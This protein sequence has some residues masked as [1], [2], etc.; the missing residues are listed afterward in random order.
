MLS[1]ESTTFNLIEISPSPEEIENAN[2][3]LWEKDSRVI[4]IQNVVENYFE[5]SSKA[6]KVCFSKVSNS[7]RTSPKE[8]LKIPIL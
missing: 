2:E 6:S 7:E 5:K 4:K 3:I 1:Q 8:A